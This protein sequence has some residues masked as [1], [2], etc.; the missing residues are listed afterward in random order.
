M[1]AVRR[2]ALPRMLRQALT[3]ARRDFIATVATPT[4]L[5]FL[6]APLIMV[7]I[8]T[9]GGLGAAGVAGSANETRRIVAIVSPALAPAVIEA[10]KRLRR[11]ARPPDGPPALMVVRPARDLAA[12]ARAILQ[13]DGAHDA[14][15]VLHGPLGRPGILYAPGNQ[16]HA[17]YLALLADD[18]L[19][20]H[21][22]GIRPLAE[23]QVDRV[24]RAAA[25]PAAQNQLGF[26]AVFGIFFLTLLLAGQA[27]GTMAEE[28][29]SKVIEILAASAPLEAVFLG[30]LLGMFGVA[31]LFVGFWGSVLGLGVA[32]A[33]P[34]LSSALSGATPAIGWPAFAAL[35]LIYF[36]LSYL[37]LGATFLGIGAQASTPREIQMLSLPITIVQVGM[38]ALAS[39]TASKPESNLARIA[40]LFPLSSPLAMA[41][42]AG[43][44]A[45]IWPHLVAIPWAA[46]WVALVITVGARAFRRGVLQSGTATPRWLARLVRRGG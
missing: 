7:S 40:E 28:R 29:S 8:G 9:I 19:A 18:A 12:Q 24:E 37:L 2:P 11:I 4:F 27:I 20:L 14:T 17:D 5:L 6:L 32:A 34:E 13:G 46:L 22:G 30:K 38:F 16:R 31:V 39:A 25:S 42:R 21:A 36:T 26:F 41:A 33:P 10:D 45:E 43:S 3:V 1:S 23:P 15:A 35:F 44:R